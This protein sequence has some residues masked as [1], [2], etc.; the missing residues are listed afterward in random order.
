MFT[1]WNFSLIISIFLSAHHPSF[2]N[3]WRVY[4]FSERI[5]ALLCSSLLFTSPHP[6]GRYPAWCASFS[7]CGSTVSHHGCFA[8][9]S[10]TW[11]SDRCRASSSFWKHCSASQRAGGM[12]TVP[13]A[14]HCYTCLAAYLGSGSSCSGCWRGRMRRGHNL[15]IP[16]DPPKSST[17]SV[18]VSAWVA[19][20]GKIACTAK[21][22]A[23]V[24]F[25][26]GFIVGIAVVFQTLLRRQVLTMTWKRRE[27]NNA[28]LCVHCTSRSRSRCTDRIHA[29]VQIKGVWCVWCTLN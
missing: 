15:V 28:S 24:S 18:G 2:S 29:E 25:V 17:R 20:A 9:P 6:F 7:N 8:C 14:C 11:R 13:L 12:G 3:S 27:R 16:A 4:Q 21:A 19:T 26:L 5:F 23:I 10:P 1:P 22:W